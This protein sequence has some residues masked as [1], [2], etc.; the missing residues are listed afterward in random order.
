MRR[1]FIL[2]VLSFGLLVT[3]C[4]QRVVK[5]VDPDQQIDLSGRW[6]DVDSKLVAKE[7]IQDVL[8]RPWR[9]NFESKNGRKP[10]VIIGIVKNKSSEHIDAE[11]FIKDM[12]K[13][14]INTATVKVVQGGEFR[15]QIR[16]E[17]ADQQEYA[18]PETMKKWKK[19]MG[20]DFMMTGVISSITDEY[21]KQKVVY[22]QINLEL[23]D[24]ESNEKVWLNDKKIKKLINN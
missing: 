16:K 24:M 10:V 17:R 23:S 2:S 7:M 18:S 1:Y 8:N 5:R 11:N 21:G 9:T 6:N 12:E 13:E 19:E 22:Y 3:G 15:E 20:A 4:Q 14:F